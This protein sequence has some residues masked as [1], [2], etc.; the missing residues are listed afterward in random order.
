MLT[1]QSADARVELA[2]LESCPKAARECLTLGNLLVGNADQAAAL[3]IEGGSAEIAL[4]GAA[5]HAAV[6]GVGASAT[7]ELNGMPLPEATLFW[8]MDGATLVVNSGG[9]AATA[10][11]RA[12]GCLAAYLFVA[13]GLRAEGA[14]AD[15]FLTDKRQTERREVGSYLARGLAR[16]ANESAPELRV[17]ADAAPD[18]TA[19]LEGIDCERGELSAGGSVYPVAA[20]DLPLLNRLKIGTRLKLRAVSADEH[21]RLAAERRRFLRQAGAVVAPP[22]SYGA[23]AVDG[24]ERRF[25]YT[26]LR[27]EQE[28]G[29]ARVKSRDADAV[30]HIE[31]V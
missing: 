25:E 4:Q 18:W 12:A 21:R 26:P 27:M 23:L 29:Q 8:A 7:V 28:F 14:Q 31:R 22:R 15:A 16:V 19:T 6:I 24:A 2:T 10:D 9:D 17:I 3:R 20:P 11:E 5:L 13:G 30:I 1:L